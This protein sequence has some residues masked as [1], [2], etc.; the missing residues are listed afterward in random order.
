MWIALS[1]S[2]HQGRSISGLRTRAPRT[3]FH[4]RPITGLIM[5][6]K[7]KI[8]WRALSSPEGPLVRL[9]TREWQELESRLSQSTTCTIKKTRNERLPKK[10]CTGKT[11]LKDWS[12]FF[13]I[14]G[15]ASTWHFEVL[16]I[17]YINQIMAIFVDFSNCFL[18]LTMYCKNTKIELMQDKCTTITW[19]KLSKIN[20]FTLVYNHICSISQSYTIISQSYTI[21]YG[22][23]IK[24]I[25]VQPIFEHTR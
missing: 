13:I 7:R 16:L 11:F 1:M 15:L 17:N 3:S 18:N 4:C 20:W 24:P 9:R 25:T 12:K 10:G 23:I 6:P 21:A 14:S 19:E 8:S 22:K 5:G 2:Q